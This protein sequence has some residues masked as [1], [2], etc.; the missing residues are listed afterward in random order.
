MVSGLRNNIG[1]T[2]FYM[3]S[4]KLMNLHWEYIKF[5]GILVLIFFKCFYK[6][7]QMILKY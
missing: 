5:E 4:Y 3:H 2:Y 1:D 7:Y 6:K